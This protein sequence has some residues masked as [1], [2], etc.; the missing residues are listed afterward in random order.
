MSSLKGC[1]YNTLC[2]INNASILSSKIDN[3]SKALQYIYTYIYIALCKINNANTT[4]SY[5]TDICTTNTANTVN[6]KDR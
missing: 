4:N 6:N 2:N 5:I 3:A 1:K